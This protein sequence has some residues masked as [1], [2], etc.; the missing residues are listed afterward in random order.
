M[1]EHIF[2]SGYIV[3]DQ[4]IGQVAYEAFCAACAKEPTALWTPRL[5]WRDL[6]PARQQSWDDMANAVLEATLPY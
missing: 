4:P 3:R 6:P 2:A 5:P 1:S